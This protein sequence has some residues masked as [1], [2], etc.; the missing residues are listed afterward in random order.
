M[1]TRAKDD[2]QHVIDLINKLTFVYAFFE[3]LF[4]TGERVETETGRSCKWSQPCQDQYDINFST[5]MNILATII[6]KY[7]N[8]LIKEDRN[9]IGVWRNNLS[10]S[11]Y[12]NNNGRAANSFAIIEDL[13]DGNS[14]FKLTM[15]KYMIWC[16]YAV[17]FLSKINREIYSDTNFEGDKDDHFKVI[18]NDRVKNLAFAYDRCIQNKNIKEEN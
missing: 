13:K 17:A 3:Y 1:F 12:P 15:N 6:E 10:Y 4:K 5:G 2:H 14:K 9:T 7:S 11:H 8:F 16:R 18:V